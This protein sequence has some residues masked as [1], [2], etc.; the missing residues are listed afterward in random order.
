LLSQQRVRRTFAYVNNTRRVPPGA[1]P[2]RG[3]EDLDDLADLF[4]QGAA[5]GTPVRESSGRTRGVAV[6]MAG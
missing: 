2:W 6:G 4:E 3:R 1:K 5:D